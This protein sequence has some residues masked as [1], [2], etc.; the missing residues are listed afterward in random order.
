MNILTYILIAIAVGS[1]SRYLANKSDESAVEISNKRV[2]K[3]D[4]ALGYL[5]LLSILLGAVF[6]VLYYIDVYHRNN[7]S[8]IMSFFMLIIFGSIGLYLFLYYKNT[9]VVYNDITVKT[10]NFLNKSKI[11]NW[12]DVQE[13]VYLSGP[14]WLCL[15]SENKKVNVPLTIKGFNQFT[16][17]LEQKIAVEKY[18]DAFAKMRS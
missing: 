14:K 2:M 18:E 1:F 11:I 5:G 17:V 3:A 4:K 12:S 8:L 16:K 7:R 15:K 6:P 13:V 10:T 9:N